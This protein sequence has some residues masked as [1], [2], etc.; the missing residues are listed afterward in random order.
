[1]GKF[2]DFNRVEKQILRELAKEVLEISK[3]PEQNEKRKLWY[4]LN[5]LE[6]TRPVIFCDPENGWKEIISDK[7][8][9]CENKFA[10][11]F[12]FRL[13]KEIFWGRKMGDDRVVEAIFNIPYIYE[14]ISWGLDELVIGKI[15]GHAYNWEPMLKDYDIDFYKLKFPVININYEATNELKAIADEIFEGVLEVRTNH[16]WW[17]SLGLT[18]E[19]IKLRGFERFLYDMYDYPDEVHKTMSFLR[20]GTL[21]MIDFLENSN[22]L[23]LN[24]DGTYVGSGGFGYTY[25]L[26]SGDFK[27]KVF[28]KDMWGFA[29]SQET[30]GVSPDMFKEFIFPYQFD[31]LKRFGL[32]CYGC[33]EAIENRWHLIKEIP[34]LRRVSV[35]PWANHSVMADYL[36]NEFIFS[37][38]PNP[39]YIAISNPDFEAIKRDLKKALEI[40]KDCR[41]EVIMKDNNTLGNNPDNAIQWVKI[42]KELALS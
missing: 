34:N 3:L 27:G 11:D 6:P 18:S 33:C 41:V 37:M 40:T 29:E 2:I 19:Y 14:K 36:K 8:L 24:N 31:I 32:N 9:Q 16:M 21:N 38:K 30:V 39:S 7:S 35:S 10:R 23:S 4:S 17:W 13:K 22:L 25:E 20:D 5:N 28:S 42:A 15:D 12:E 1:M 26:P